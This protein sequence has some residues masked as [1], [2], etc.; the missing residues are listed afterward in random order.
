MFT[1]RFFK[2]SSIRARTARALLAALAL[3]SAAGVACK[4]DYPAGAQQKGPGGGGGQR[5]AREVRVARVDE[6]PVG[7]TVTVNGTLAAF[8]QTT[9][10]VKVP[11]RLQGVAVDLG[12]TVRKGQ[13]IARV[14]PRDYEL[15][16]QQA[17]AAL[18]QA[19]ARLSLSLNGSDETVDPER[20][21]TVREARALMDEARQ[22]RDRAATLVQS[23]VI[24]RAE[25]DATL[26]ALKV[27]ESRYQDAVEEIR[28]RQALLSQR[29]TELSL[30]RQQL[31]DTAVHAP[32]DGVVEEKIASVGEYLAAGAPVVRIVKMN[33]L[34][35]QA[36]VPER[37]AASVRAGQMLRVTVEGSQRA[38]A[39]R[40]VRINP[41]IKE[42]SR[43]LVV[44]ADISNDGL[45][46]PGAFAR[47][48]I[49]VN[50]A[51]MAV[52]VPPGAIV[53][54]AGIEK[55]IVVDNGRAQE[56]PVTTGR[57]AAEW[58]EIISGVNVGDSVVL[59]P[60]NLQ[61][62]TPVNVVQ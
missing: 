41:V 38:Y 23:G 24:A 21:G 60:G 18:Q 29:R 22:N 25:Y 37:E 9:V 54:F 34:R 17:D 51:Q 61:S 1:Q 16:V 48:E 3:V 45:L 28:N 39:G 7:Q 10:S 27:A 32:F 53:T 6:M 44:E 50:D 33:P 15:R 35:F 31:Q 12:T 30:A 62:G 58:T 47:A 52:T 4:S 20:T 57:R 2:H 26:A 13:L 56:K 14:E 8:D 43:V 55:V 40:I 11:G 59:E 19:R 36:E 5:E 42:Q 46:R 49:V